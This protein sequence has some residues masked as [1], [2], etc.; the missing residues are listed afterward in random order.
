[1]RSIVVHADIGAPNRVATHTLPDGTVRRFRPVGACF[2]IDNKGGLHAGGEAVMP[3]P[4]RPRA[5]EPHRRAHRRHARGH[6]P[7]ARIFIGLSVGDKPPTRFDDVV[8]ATVAIRKRQAS[9]PDASFLAQRG[10]YTQAGSTVEENSVQMIIIDMQGTRSRS[11]RA[12]SWS[13]PKELREDFKQE[14]VIVEIQ[15]RG[16]VVDV[17]SVTAEWYEEGHKAPR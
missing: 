14:S 7:S 12:R 4:R 2:I 5:R 10:V 13:W 9:L 3:A 6:G 1:M 16:V 8:K 15:K 17:F 11:S